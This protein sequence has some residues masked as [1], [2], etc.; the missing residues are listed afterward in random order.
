MLRLNLG[1]RWNSPG[2]VVEARG[3]LNENI[4]AVYSSAEITDIVFKCW[5]SGCPLSD[6]VVL[7][8]GVWSDCGED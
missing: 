4:F 7:L 8:A 5:T 1:I 3:V 2:V 6:N